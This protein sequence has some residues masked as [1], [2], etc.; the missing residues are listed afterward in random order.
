MNSQPESAASGGSGSQNESAASGGSGSQR[1]TT[2][3]SRGGGVGNILQ[4]A[5][6]HGLAKVLGA[7]I[8]NAIFQSG[9]TPIIVLGVVGFYTGALFATSNAS[10]FS[11]AGSACLGALIQMFSSSGAG[12]TTT[13]RPQAGRGSARA[14][15]ESSSSTGSGRAA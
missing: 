10:L 7:H 4:Y 1:A 3:S 8:I 12:R 11:N 2:S 13:R 14:Q 15:E 5:E 6:E 9:L